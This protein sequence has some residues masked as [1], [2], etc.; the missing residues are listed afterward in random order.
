MC[1]SKRTIV[2]YRIFPSLKIHAIQQRCYFRFTTQHASISSRP[3]YG[4]G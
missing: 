1:T 2:H 3:H 4:Q